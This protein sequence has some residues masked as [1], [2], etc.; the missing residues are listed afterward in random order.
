M[1][2]KATRS[3]DIGGRGERQRV[4]QMREE[5]RMSAMITCTETYFLIPFILE[6]IDVGLKTVSRTLGKEVKI[7]IF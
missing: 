1:E 6:N 5:G 4:R 7:Q 2:G 3:H